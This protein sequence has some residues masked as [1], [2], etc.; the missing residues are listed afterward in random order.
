MELLSPIPGPSAVLARSR[1]GHCLVG[2]GAWVQRWVGGLA[3]NSGIWG[4]QTPPPPGG[5][6]ALFL[7][8][9]LRSVLKLVVWGCA[10]FSLTRLFSKKEILS[11]GLYMALEQ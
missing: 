3:P 9:C 10:A 7:V 2:V 1:P 4:H 8:L 6:G 5:G 11:L